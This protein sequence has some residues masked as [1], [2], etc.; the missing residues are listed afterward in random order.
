MIIFFAMTIGYILLSRTYF[1]FSIEE[2]FFSSSFDVSTKF[3]FT[4][5]EACVIAA[6]SLLNGFPAVNTLFYSLSCD[7]AIKHF[8]IKLVFHA[9]RYLWQKLIR[10]LQ[11]AKGFVQ[12]KHLYLFLHFY[13]NK[14]MVY[15]S[16]Q[17]K[18]IMRYIHQTVS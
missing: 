13:I 6:C 15:A 2:T 10:K 7:S 1:A 8:H 16:K 5:S 3:T 18:I 11:I 12:Q 14:K 4:F 17:E 9:A